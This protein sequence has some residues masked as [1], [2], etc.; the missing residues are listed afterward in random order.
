MLTKVEITKIINSL[1]LD[2]ELVAL[3][4]ELVDGSETVT[5]EMLNTI[6]D[7]LETNADFLDN[8]AN[9]LEE[10]ADE[11]EALVAE[12]DAIDA[13]EERDIVEAVVKGNEEVLAKITSQVQQGVSSASESSQQTS[14]AP[15]PSQDTT[16]DLDSLTKNLMQSSQG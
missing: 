5:K 8:T 3:I 7:I 12:L 11:Y 4:F 2:S 15:Q 13:E 9:L 1:N 6:A 16:S 14:P 10:E